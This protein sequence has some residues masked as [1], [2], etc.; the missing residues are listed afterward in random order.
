[1]K[2]NFSNTSDCVSFALCSKSKDYDSKVVSFVLQTNNNFV[3]VLFM[4]KLSF[5]NPSVTGLSIFKTSLV[6]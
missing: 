3:V 1:M 4:F 2:A 5:Q 6:S